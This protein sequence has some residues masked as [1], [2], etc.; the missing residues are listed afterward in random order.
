M[1]PYSGKTLTIEAEG[2]FSEKIEEGAYALLT[3]KYGLIRVIYQ[4]EDLCEQMKNV[5]TECPLGPGVVKITKDVD[6]PESIPPVRGLPVF[7][8]YVP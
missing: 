6:I 5:D 4:K 8:V 3:V 1:I 2:T 7:A